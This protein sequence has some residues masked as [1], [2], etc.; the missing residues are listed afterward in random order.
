MNAR[1]EIPAPPPDGGAI[2]RA[3][4]EH[5]CAVVRGVIP[6]AVIGEIAERAEAAYRMR[7][8]QFARG[9]LERL[10]KAGAYPGYHMGDYHSGHCPR[11]DLDAPGEPDYDFLRR[12][13]SANLGLAL[14]DALADDVVHFPLSLCVPRRQA[15]AGP[16]AP[17]PFHQDCSFLHRYLGGARPPMLNAWTPLTPAGA[18]APGLQ[19]LP[20]ILREALPVAARKSGT[21][22]DSIEIDPDWVAE[23]W[24]E[25]ALWA[26]ALEP[27]DVIVI[28]ES[29]LHRTWVTPAMTD[30][31]LSI[32]VRAL[33]GR[34]A[35]AHGV[36]TP[37]LTLRRG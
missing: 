14:M 35:A 10:V 18:T 13:I 3:L 9:E 33:A 6:R 32:E 12:L 30:T 37:A 11:A 20:Q 2:R 31:R 24:G 26:P 29:T 36:N 21:V 7:D 16:N 15:P 25:D 17:V 23:T 1:P 28:T 34:D 5:G 4:E 8:W 19:V 22:Y 27:G